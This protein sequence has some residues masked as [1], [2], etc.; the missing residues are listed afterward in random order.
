MKYYTHQLNNGLRIVHVKN[1]SE[2]AH[3][4]LIINAGSRD[5][6]EHE[7]GIAHFIEH[8]IF[9]GTTKRKAFHILSR[10]DNVGGDIN[11][12]TSKEETF[13]HTSFI[14]NEYSRALELLSD[15][16]FSSIFPGKE[17]EKEKEVIIDEINSYKDNPSES[18][19]D[20]F[21]ELIFAGQ[22]LGRN[23]LGSPETLNK[24]NKEDFQRFVHNNYSPDQMVISSVGNISFSELIRLVEKNFNDFK[25]I[26]NGRK[27]KP[28]KNYL[29][30]TK[31]I[32]KNTSQAHCM[33]GNIGYNMY[34]PRRTTLS[35]LENITGGPGLTSRLNMLLREKLGYVY[36]VESNYTPFT[37]TGIFSVYFATD[38]NKLDKTLNQVYKEFKRL[39][40]KKLGSVQLKNAKQQL[41]G[42]IAIQS[43][44][45]SNQMI[46]NGKSYLF[47][48]KLNSLAEIRKKIKNISAEN[49]LEVANDVLKPD[50]LSVLIYQ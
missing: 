1:N 49:V 18:I 45:N 27:R 39:R 26:K 16:T 6:E 50:Q 37:D 24:F 41:F 35:L 21:E 25:P 23:I 46:A 29:P 11:A 19:F 31:V 20:D 36:H 22:P 43:E 13:I 4:G 32:D 44:V 33:L 28:F 15:L 8:L 30:E 9:K 10:M 7:Q 42:Q 14:Q 48:N 5:E 17:I 38:K 47:R 34:D 2:V 3:C 40:E 12:Y